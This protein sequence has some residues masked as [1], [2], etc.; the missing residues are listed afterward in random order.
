MQTGSVVPGPPVPVVDVVDA[1]CAKADAG[2]SVTAIGSKASTGRRNFTLERWFQHTLCQLATSARCEGSR[3]RRATIF[4]SLAAGVEGK[5]VSTTVERPLTTFRKRRCG[6]SGPRRFVADDELLRDRAAAR[7]GRP[8]VRAASRPRS[9]PR[10]PPPEGE[11]AEQALGAFEHRAGP[12][13]PDR[14]KRR[15][16]PRRPRPRAGAR[17]RQWPLA[18]PRARTRGARCRRTT[19]RRTQSTS[20]KIPPRVPPTRSK[21]R[22]RTLRTRTLAERSPNGILERHEN[23]EGR[24]RP[25]GEPERRLCRWPDRRGGRPRSARSRARRRG[26]RAARPGRA[27]R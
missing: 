2:S 7:R 17:A 26:A 8:N 23:L 10:P 5:A 16:G 27:C 14:R 12:T 19:N 6:W 4:A 24:A 1:A 25:N 13:R 15:G 18:R 22:N 3:I 21:F 11:G 20:P 9:R